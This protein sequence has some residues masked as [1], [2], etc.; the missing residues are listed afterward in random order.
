M[1]LIQCA[2]YFALTGFIGFLAGRII[3][4]KWINPRGCLYR[5]RDFEQG[6]R[7]YEKIGIHRWHHALPSMSRI[8]P[9][10]IPPKNLKGNWRDRLPRMIHETCVAELIHWLLCISGFYCLRL[11]QGMGGFFVTII[12][13]LLL[14]LP[15]ILIQRYNRPRLII[16]HQKSIQRERRIKEKTCQL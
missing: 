1:K 9:F 5:C 7:L 12:N 6:G 3:P 10:M 2:V 13:I 8:L 11:W 4:E 14:N 16:L 15:F